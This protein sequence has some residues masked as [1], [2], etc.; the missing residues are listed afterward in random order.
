MCFYLRNWQVTSLLY[1]LGVFI[2]EYTAKALRNHATIAW[3]SK[4]KKRLQGIHLKD[5]IAFM[6]VI[7]HP[8]KKVVNTFFHFSSIFPLYRT[9]VKE[10]WQSSNPLA[11]HTKS[12]FLLSLYVITELQV[13]LLKSDQEKSLP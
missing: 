3:F 12:L 13:Q 11:M 7:I 9:S 1:T 2:T 10:R 5:A 6:V 8:S 4:Y